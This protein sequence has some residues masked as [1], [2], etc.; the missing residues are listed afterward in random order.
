MKFAYDGFDAQGERKTGLLEAANKVDALRELQRKAITPIDLKA[1]EGKKAPGLFT[2]RLTRQHITQALH[3]LTRLIESEV[4]IA[5]SI[6]AM[7]DAGH[8]ERI[9][10]AFAGI[11]RALQH[12]ESFSEALAFTSGPFR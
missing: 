4:S 9:D 5:E 11:A 6:G 1:D 2:P 8:H 12:G 7:T 10:H 3:E